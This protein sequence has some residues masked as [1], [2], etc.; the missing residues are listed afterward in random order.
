MLH[1]SLTLYQCI[2]CTKLEYIYYGLMFPQR[3]SMVLSLSPM[4]NG[5]LSVVDDKYAKYFSF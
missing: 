4:R 3:V 1:R 2:H 5:D